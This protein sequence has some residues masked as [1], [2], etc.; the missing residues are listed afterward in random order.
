MTWGSMP[1][2][3]DLKARIGGVVKR[4]SDSGVTDN[5]LH[6]GGATP[7]PE[8]IRSPAAAATK[9][10]QEQAFGDWAE[11]TL[12]EAISKASNAF[13]AVH[14]GMS[15]KVV[16]G[17]EGFKEQYA[18]GIYDTCEFG[19]RPDLLIVP[20]G[21]DVPNDISDVATK[22]LAGVVAQSLGAVE[23]RSSRTEVGVR[24]TY[25]EAQLLAKKKVTT[26]EL[27][28]TV[29]VEDLVKVFR[30]VEVFDRPQAYAQVF[31]DEVHAIGVREILDYIV[32]APRLKVE[33]YERNKKYTIMVPISTGV[34]IGCVAQYPEFEVVDR[35]TRD[36]RHDIYAR[37]TGGRI[38]VDWAKLEPVFAT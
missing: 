10:Q 35:T 1:Y 12:G 8:R 27:N 22:D 2:S 18:A 20:R 19:K 9:F 32:N 6:F 16:A 31:L 34:K 7:P 17:E 11:A 15:S 28:F 30:W 13:K 36:G 33:E 25:V 37:P 24:K 4:L 29:K 26:P 3:A 38:D 23:V 5:M 21:I 14:Y